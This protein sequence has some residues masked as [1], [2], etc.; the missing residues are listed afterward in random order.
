MEVCFDCSHKPWLVS[1]AE[2]LYF[3]PPH[4]EKEVHTLSNR[5]GQ[6][7]VAH[8]HTEIHLALQH[9]HTEIHLVLQHTHTHLV[10]QN[11]HTHLVLQHTHHQLWFTIH[12]RYSTP[13]GW[14]MLWYSASAIFRIAPDNT[15][16]QGESISKNNN[17]NHSLLLWFK[18][19]VQ[20][21]YW[22]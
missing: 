1:S 8:T 16:Q 11:A 19:F 22:N 17:T 13:T 12:Y 18:R 6:G 20:L 10:L 9:A 2:W 21:S 3:S 4:T 5:V 7:H 15:E 14:V